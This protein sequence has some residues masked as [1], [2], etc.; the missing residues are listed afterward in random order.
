MVDKGKH[1]R[2]V[3]VS[4]EAGHVGVFDPS[5]LPSSSHVPAFLTSIRTRIRL[6]SLRFSRAWRESTSLATSERSAPPSDLGPSLL[7]L[8]HAIGLDPGIDNPCRF[9]SPGRIVAADKHVDVRD[10]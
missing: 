3:A 8:D 9:R 7:P 1:N 2:L 4:K 10:D 6:F 5:L